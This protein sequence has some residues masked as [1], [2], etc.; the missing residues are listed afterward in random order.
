V[1]HTPLFWKLYLTYLLAVVLC[2]G[3]V[4]W[5]AV[6][7]ASS[8]YH[9]QAVSDLKARAELATGRVVPLLDRP[10]AL[11]ALARS[12]GTGADTRV[13]VIAGPDAALGV[14]GQVLADSEADPATMPNHD[15][16]TRPEVQAAL[17]G[18]TGEVTR[19]S[20]TIKRRMIYVAVPVFNADHQVEAVIRT[21]LPLTQI[22]DKVN[23]MTW[24]IVLGTLLMALVVALLGLLVS[25]SI[26][27]RMREIRLGAGRFAGGDFAHEIHVS[28]S[29]EIGEV[30]AG[31]N[32]MGRQLSETIQT[33]T[34]ERNQTEAVL[35][36]MTEGVLAVDAEE[37]IIT[38]NAAAAALLG[39]EPEQ[40]RGRSIQEIVRNPE[41][42]RFVAAVLA[43]EEPVEGD[44]VVHADRDPRELRVHGAQLRGGN[45]NAGANGDAPG[46]DKGAVIVLNDVTRMR[47]YEAIRRDFVANVSHEIKT[48]VTTIKGFAE[49]L[50]DGALD[51]R[52]DAERFLRIIVGQADRMSAITEDLLSLSSL[53]SG[54]EDAAITLERGSIRDVLQV[55]LGVCQMKAEAKHISLG[56]DCPEALYAEINPPLLE[57]AVVNLIDNAVKYSSEGSAVGVSATV[58]GTTLSIKVADAGRGIA[59]EHLPRLFER[60]YR[61]DKARSR[62]MGGTG[63][64]LS[65]VKHIAVA[66]GGWVAVESAPGLGS[67]FTITLPV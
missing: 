22:S 24:R 21:A 4:G 48:P 14:E 41:L 18:A 23:A 65:I 66:H 33:I 7:T 34:A 56:L 40:A 42:Q 31:L 10:A 25:R 54:S 43:G 26:S 67:T 6:G 46:G 20:E 45:G 27:G 8:L 15:D 60:F 61:V 53:E 57:Q 9:Q 12:I 11:Q 1:R 16:P 19:F 62:D 29:D 2:A 35:A 64:G 55:A 30:A 59:R 47:H 32:V 44:V 39:V 37:R 5:L 3:V 49:T 13:T 36:G 28:T 51:D 17:N 50:L 38:I 58:R 52:A 63:L